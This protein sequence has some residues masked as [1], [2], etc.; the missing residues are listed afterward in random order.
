[1]QRANQLKAIY[2]VARQSSCHVAPILAE[3]E[4]RLKRA[5][6]QEPL[7]SHVAIQA[8]AK[9]VNARRA[10]LEHVDRCSVC[11]RLNKQATSL[12]ASEVR[13]LGD[14][15][16]NLFEGEQMRLARLECSAKHGDL[17]GLDAGGDRGNY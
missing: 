17:Q 5:A 15:I 11:Q 7:N 8:Y 3:L 6:E 2:K 14:H 13:A 1:M 10:R 16:D 9:L 4:S 12:N